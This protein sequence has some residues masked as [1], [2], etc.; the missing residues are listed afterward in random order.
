[1]LCLNYYLL[2]L[3]WLNDRY[4]IHGLWPQFDP[5]HYPEYCRRVTFNASALDG[6]YQQL[7]TYW[8]SDTGNN[9][10]FWTHEW[11]KH[12]SCMFNNCTQRQYFQTTLDLF[13]KTTNNQSIIS[14]CGNNDCQISFSQNFIPIP[15]CVAISTN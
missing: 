12:G 10:E 3:L 14:K 4:T 9:T 7:N 1:M 15:N 11:T 13:F 6:M 2:A 8:I 5:Q